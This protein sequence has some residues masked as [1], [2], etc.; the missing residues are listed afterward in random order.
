[1]SPSLHRCLLR[2]S[3]FAVLTTTVRA[4][5]ANI[6]MFADPACALPVEIIWPLLD[7]DDSNQNCTQFDTSSNFYGIKAT[8][9]A[10]GCA[11]K[12]IPRHP[13]RRLTVGHAADSC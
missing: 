9:L 2:L 1:M 8:Y 10:Q 12:V 13:T 4:A 5:V 11:R 6:T 3:F 7:Q